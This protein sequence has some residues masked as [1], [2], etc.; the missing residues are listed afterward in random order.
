MKYLL[1]MLAVMALLATS[2][3]FFR[4]GGDRGDHRGGGGHDEHY[5][6]GDHGGDHGDNH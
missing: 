6:G 2:G 1:L 3:C 5:S 4:G